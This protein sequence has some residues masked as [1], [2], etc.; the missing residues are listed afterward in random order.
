MST[1]NVI[2]LWQTKTL[3]NEFNENKLAPLM[4]AKAYLEEQHIT[5]TAAAKQLHVT[6]QYLGNVLNG[7][8][9]PGRKLAENFERFSN[10]K[11][12]AIEML[13]LNNTKIDSI[14]TPFFKR[15]I[16]FLR[17]GHDRTAKD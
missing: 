4:D 9:V 5:I 17:R 16:I 7:H 3:T 14:T 15:L 13:K 12:T 6:R 8:T 2:K 11:V 1:I 10:G